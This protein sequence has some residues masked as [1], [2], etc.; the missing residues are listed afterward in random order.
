MVLHSVR[1]CRQSDHHPDAGGRLW[2]RAG[3]LDPARPAELLLV[4]AERHS[5]GQ[6]GH[7]AG[8]YSLLGNARTAG[9]PRAGADHHRQ[10]DADR[11]PLRRPGD[12]H[13]RGLE[14]RARLVLPLCRA[15]G[16][17]ADLGADSGLW[18]GAHDRLRRRYPAD[19]RP[20]PGRDYD[21]D[22]L[23]GAADARACRP[24]GRDRRAEPVAYGG[25]GDLRQPH[26]TECRGR[27]G[28]G[29]GGGSAAAGSGGN[30]PTIYVDM[31]N[32]GVV[33]GRYSQEWHGPSFGAAT[34][35]AALPPASSPQIIDA[36]Q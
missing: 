23:Q 24:G 26:G 14:L 36:E 31:R 27:G 9:H 6:P 7:R 25:A 28:G 2:R 11:Q 16:D 5:G 21:A 20:D 15:A 1:P 29:D 35:R 19:P 3:K 32:T 12:G 10:P 22:G 8:D 17:P 30:A 34:S 4:V 33:D 18:P 13:R